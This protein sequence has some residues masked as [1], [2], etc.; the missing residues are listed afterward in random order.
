MEQLTKAPI[1]TID[2]EQFFT[3]K[4]TLENLQ[5]MQLEINRCRMVGSF[6]FVLSIAAIICSIFL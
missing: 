3:A 5:H 1:V 4:W 2:G 6:S